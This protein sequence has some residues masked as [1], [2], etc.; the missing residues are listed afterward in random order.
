M[1]ILKHLDKNNLHHAYLVEGARDEILPEIFSFMEVLNIPILNNPDFC[2]INIDN[3]KMDEVIL[4]RSMTSD[5]SFSGNKKIFVISAN[6]F[7]LD[8]EHALLKIFEEPKKDTHFFL[9]VPDKNALLPTL[10]SRFY[11]IASEL[12]DKDTEEVESFIKMSVSARI[13]F[14]KDFLKSEDEN[15]EVVAT[16]S[17]RAKSLRFLNNLEFILADKFEKN[18]SS[19]TLPGV[20]GGA[21]ATQNSFQI[22]LEQIFKVRKFLRQ[23]GSSTKSLMESLALII[24]NI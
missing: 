19:V 17:I 9:I 22:C 11:Y 21:L 4:L 3:F 10:F 7:S 5:K 13:N 2:Q 14:L 16:D 23:P 1:N 24:P 18:F 12:G 8:A 15:E 20:P 6:Q